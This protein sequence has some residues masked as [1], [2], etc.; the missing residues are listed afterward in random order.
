[1]ARRLDAERLATWR[2]LRA[3]VRAV[4]AEIDAVL[5]DEHGIERGAYEVL[6]YLEANGGQARVQEVADSLVIN[7]STFTRLVDRLDSSGWV[8][9]ELTVDDGR[10]LVLVLTARG[11][12]T[13]AK[14]RPAYRRA[15]QRSF[16]QH[17]TDTDL[18][19]LQRLLG[20]LTT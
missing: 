3:S 17:V 10:G 13:A 4:D 6:A 7:R 12:R 15:V 18:A 1:M 5:R 14:V 2:L 16:N 20:K 9:R 11:W 19:A 8:T